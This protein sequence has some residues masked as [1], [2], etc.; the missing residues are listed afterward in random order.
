MKNQQMI[1]KTT[2]FLGIYF[3][4]AVNSFLHA[5]TY[6]INLSSPVAATGYTYDQTW[7]KITFNAAANGNKYFITGNTSNNK[8]ISIICPTMVND[9]VLTLNNITSSFAIIE[10]QGSAKV[11]LHLQG[12]NTMTSGII[13]PQNAT[14]IIDSETAPGSESGVLNMTLSASKDGPAIGN[15]GNGTTTAG[16][17]GQIII[18]GG[19][20]NIK[21]E[22]DT[23][24]AI[25]SGAGHTGNVTINGGNVKAVSAYNGAAI[26]G[27]NRG[28]GHVTI[29]GG[30]IDA[31][32][33]SYGAAIGGGGGGSC[34]ITI[35]G[36]TI[37]AETG[38]YSSGGGYGAAIGNGGAATP[39]TSTGKSTIKITGGTITT[40]T[41]GGAGIGSAD[42]NRNRPEYEIS[43]AADIVGFSKGLFYDQSCIH[44]DGVN[45]GDGYF[46]SIYVYEWAGLACFPKGKI[47]VYAHGDR[48]T[49]LRVI[50]TP[51]IYDVF[52]YTTGATARQNDNIYINTSNNAW[53][54]VIR[55]H[56]NSPIIY[57]VHSMNE[58]FTATG[59]TIWTLAVKLGTGTGNPNYFVVTEKHV[60]K[61]GN[62][63]PGV[64]DGA[65][66]VAAN[67]NYIRTIPAISTYTP[68][69]FK[70]D[71]VP[72]NTCNDFTTGDPQSTLINSNKTIYFVYTQYVLPKITITASEETTC[73]TVTF[74]TQ[75]ENAGSSPTYQWTVNGVNK[76]TNSNT[77]TYLPNNG[78]KVMCA[79]TSS[80]PNAN[81]RTV[82]SNVVT[83]TVPT[84]L[85]ANTY[86]TVSGNTSICSGDKTTLT[87]TASALSSPQFKWYSD[88]TA[89][90]TVLSQGADYQ[91]PNLTSTTTYYVAV[92]SSGYCETAPGDRKAVTVTVGCGTITGTVF[93][94]VYYNNPK[95]DKMFAVV[96]RLYD[97]T[98][99]PRD[100][101]IIVKK[102]T[103]YTDTAK[104][105]NGLT[106]IQNTP[107]YPGYLGQQNNPG[108]SIN[109]KTMGIT[110]GAVNNVPLTAGE[111]PKSD[112][113][114]FKISSIPPG[115]YI[116]VLSRVG[117][118][119]RFAYITVT[120]N[121]IL[122]GHRELIPGDVTENFE[123]NERDLEY[124]LPRISI[125]GENKYDPTYDLNGDLKVDMFDISL[126]KSYIGFRI[127][128][129][130]DTLDALSRP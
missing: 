57:S 46:T 14:L 22:S 36:G 5:A 67:T 111:R 91:T 25:G 94:F 28:M 51:D 49:P 76:G 41:G 54:Q 59:A 95:Y 4:L 24:A 116:L 85:N 63:I 113:G 48:T 13:V 87:A 31:A 35:T 83:I 37:K 100:P 52:Y 47:Y 9:V 8:V 60:D 30:T 6:T 40:Y 62:P 68:V 16:N 123:I 7:L 19:T 27:G 38:P 90:A 121:D 82:N 39:M 32:S 73:S 72:N 43:S 112:I 71:N 98:T 120:G 23:Y 127:R 55:Q 65:V 12:T 34:D 18:N 21:Q 110:Q 84:R 20:L 44:G 130:N 56:D 103:P 89:S 29:T 58:Y 99:V 77:F 124:I 26:G 119:Y 70:W 101:D 75:T 80:E 1:L 78:D 53:R 114:Y 104:Y 66:M 93:P 106:F 96:A 105:Y 122:V 128:L 102:L 61:C 10:L 11:N 2:L 81:P 3:A 86:V 50:A 17:T 88:N 33:G 125:Y 45:K 92:Y 74:T 97:A 107:K 69:G 64:N 15:Y 108:L 117:Y 129:Y 118:A 109:W 115:E 79:L 126:L 42:G